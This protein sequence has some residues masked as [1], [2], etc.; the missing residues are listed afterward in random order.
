MGYKEVTNLDADL[1]IALGKTDK[2]TGKKYP[3]QAEGYYLGCRSV[4]SKRGKSKIHFLQTANGNLGL[5]GTMDLNRKLGEAAPGSMVRITS[6]GTKPTP[7][8]DMYIYKVEVDADNSIEVSATSDAASYSDDDHSEDEEFSAD[9]ENENDSFVAS[10]SAKDRA[11]AV[12]ALL[13]GKGKKV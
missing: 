8:G 7:K 10:Q 4:E 5:W 3:K 1:I 6:T 2:R 12:Q 9:T 11:A 13:S